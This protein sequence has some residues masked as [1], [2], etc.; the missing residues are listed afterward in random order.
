M[1]ARRKIGDVNIR[2]YWTYRRVIEQRRNSIILRIVGDEESITIDEYVKGLVCLSVFS[3]K[4]HPDLFFQHLD[5][6][7]PHEIW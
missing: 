5:G 2:A 6:I 3:W 1:I 4:S 7:V